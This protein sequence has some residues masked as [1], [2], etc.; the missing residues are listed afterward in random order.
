MSS[1]DIKTRSNLIFDLF[2][3]KNPN[4]Q[5]ELVFNSVFELLIAVVLSA[6]ATDISVNKV[7]EKLFKVANT[8][9]KI[10]LLGHD[11]LEKYIMSIGLFRT[12]TNNIIN[13]SKKIIENYNSSVPNNYEDLI[14]LDGVGRKTANVI[15]N[16][17]FKKPTIAVDTHVFR[18]SNRIGL[19]SSNNIKEVEFQLLKIIKKKYILN[20]HNWLVLHGRYIC[21]ARNPDCKKCFLNH[22]C[23]YDK[24]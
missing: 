11:N 21:K 12:K 4:P 23:T 16:V 18:V 17:C 1:M 22:L 10:L 3:I 7:T 8:P 20:A 2:L 19:V 13:L 6:Q 9:E 5:S 24:K 14:Q 15:L